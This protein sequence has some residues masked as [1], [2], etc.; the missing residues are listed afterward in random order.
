MAVPDCGCMEPCVTDCDTL[1]VMVVKGGRSGCETRHA[2]RR[3]PELLTLDELTE[4]VGMSVRNVRFYTTKGLVPPP[5][6]R[7][8]SRLLHRRPRRP[9][10]AGAGAA[11]PRLHAVGDREVRRAASPPTPPPRTSPCTAPCSRPG[12]PTPREELPAAELER[13]A[14]RRSDDG[15]PRRPS[16]RWASCCPAAAGGSRSRVSQLGGR[17]RPARPRLPDRGGAARR[18][19]STPRTGA[20]SPRSSTSCS[21]PRSGRSTRSRASRPEQIQEVVERLKPLSI[22]SPGAGLRSRH[23]RDPARQHRQARP[24]S[25]CRAPPCGVRRMT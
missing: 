16:R 20:R 13:R 15:R 5:I 17:P 3:T 12:W 2:E 24:M 10:R 9:A 7:G 21:A 1:T 22:A 14:G 4:R 23:G 8:R 6:R 25:G 19:R 11:G 18:P